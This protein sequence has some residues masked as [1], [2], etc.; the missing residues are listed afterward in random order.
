VTPG[1]CFVCRQEG[2]RWKECRYVTEGCHLCDEKGHY[3]RNCPNRGQAQSHQQSVT[4][5]RP[6]KEPMRVTQSGV[7]ANRGRSM[8]TGNRTQGRVYHMTQEEV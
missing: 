1:R 6:E 7:S 5:D 4:V 3:R 2:H 8:S